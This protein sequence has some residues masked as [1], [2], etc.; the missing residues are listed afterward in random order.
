ML[1]YFYDLP[2]EIINYI[3]SIRLKNSIIKINYIKVIKN[4]ALMELTMK[5]KIHVTDDNYL[6]AYYCPYDKML[7]FI[8]TRCCKCNNNYYNNVI[9]KIY[10]MSLTGLLYNL[11][12]YVYE[13]HENKTNYYKTKRACDK[14]LRYNLYKI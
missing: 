10:T 1:N 11:Y 6:Q 2:D 4:M 12:N 14:L 9:D 5:L 13:N 7:P 3:Y 8:I